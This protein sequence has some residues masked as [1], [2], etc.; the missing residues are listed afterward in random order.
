MLSE[1]MREVRSGFPGREMLASWASRVQKL[2]AVAE[3]AKG[4]SNTFLNDDEFAQWEHEL[5]E[6]LKELEE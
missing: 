5:A 3:A 2:E 6:A 1:E 4:V